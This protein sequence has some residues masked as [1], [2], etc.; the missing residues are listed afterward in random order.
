[1]ISGIKG[2]IRNVSSQSIAEKDNDKQ[3]IQW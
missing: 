3:K 2:K 1:M